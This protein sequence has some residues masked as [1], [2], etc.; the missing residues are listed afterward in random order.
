MPYAANDALPPSVRSALPS[1]AQDIDREALASARGTASGRASS[2]QAVRLDATT[3]RHSRGSSP[4]P[5]ISAASHL[6]AGHTQGLNGGVTS[7]EHR[8]S[9]IRPADTLPN[10][11]RSARL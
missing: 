3:A 10:R 2:R 8:A 7:T 4:A 5:T 1:H 6:R 9:R 11:T